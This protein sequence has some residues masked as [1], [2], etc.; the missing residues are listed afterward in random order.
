MGLAHAPDLVKPFVATLSADAAALGRAR[1]AVVALLGPVDLWTDP[2]PFDA[3][4]YY[5]PEMG[6]A[7]WREFW[8]FERLA[9]PEAMADWKVGTNAIERDLAAPTGRV[10]NLDPGYVHLAHV[11]LAS[12]KPYSHRIYL[13]EGIY[14]EVTLLARKTAFETLPWTFPEYRTAAVQEFLWSVR[15]RF[16]AQRRAGG[17]A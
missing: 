11:A 14:G 17:T 12:T 2:W 9:S 10:V 6:S 7:L 13:R 3:T 1:E 15:T 5:A 8:A 16:A 4:T